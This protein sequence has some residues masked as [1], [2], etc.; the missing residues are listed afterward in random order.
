MAVIER[1]KLLLL[2]ALVVCAGL[3]HFAAG[4]S[5]YYF[6][7]LIG[8]G[9]NIIL[10]V[11]LNL[12]NGYTGQFSL[13]HAGFM[14]VGAYASSWLTLSYGYKFGAGAVSTTT[15]L[16]CACSAASR[17]ASAAAFDAA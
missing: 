3:S 15:V 5:P 16:P 13:G 4:I 1:S 14:A 10:A 11:S 9:I 8:I 2:V 7:I 6:D 17:P 12:V